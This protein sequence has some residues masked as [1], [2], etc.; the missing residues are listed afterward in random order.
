[1][2]SRRWLPA[3]LFAGLRGVAALSDAD[4]PVAPT[5][6]ALAARSQPSAGS[7]VARRPEHAGL[8]ALSDAD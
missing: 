5:G 8:A 6:P 4:G 2:R 1:V 7:A 3:R